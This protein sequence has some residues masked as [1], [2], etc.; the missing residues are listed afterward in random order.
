MPPP[1]R[2]RSGPKEEWE[3]STSEEDDDNTNTTLHRVLVVRAQQPEEE[4]TDE[5]FEVIEDDGSEA[6][7]PNVRPS[8]Q[9]TWD[10]SIPSLPTWN[11]EDNPHERNTDR[12]L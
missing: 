3:D 8:Y 2:R 6:G 10:N 5:G 12:W 1:P 4:D 9:S 7:Q 11:S